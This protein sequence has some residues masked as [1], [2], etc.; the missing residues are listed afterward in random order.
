MREMKFK[1]VLENKKTGQKIVTQAYTLDFILDEW[2][3]EKIHK[4]LEQQYGCDGN[5]TNESENHCEC[6][7]VF[8]DFE[9]V[10]RL[11]C[12]GLKD[13]GGVEIYE[14]DV[15][16]KEMSDRPY[17][18]KK[19]FCKVRSVVFWTSG[20]GVQNNDHNNKCLAKDPSVFNCEPRFTGHEILN[21]KGF[22]CHDWSVFSQCEVIGNIH[23]NPELSDK[24]N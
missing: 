13:K 16:E 19:R 2:M 6:G 9:I 4:D 12:T 23:E 5:C 7:E 10:E 18:S 15:I 1:F 8:G 21:E 14:G 17:S 24:R 3:T 20:F 11:Q 22:H